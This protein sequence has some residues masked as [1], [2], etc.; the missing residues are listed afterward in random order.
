MGGPHL[1]FQRGIDHRQQAGPGLAGA[2]G[3]LEMGD[4]D[5]FGGLIR[6]R[7]GFDPEDLLPGGG[8]IGGAPDPHLILIG[9]IRLTGALRHALPS[10]L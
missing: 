8:V 10:M 1:F 3:R 6:K 7:Q 9:D 4:I 5:V 2:P